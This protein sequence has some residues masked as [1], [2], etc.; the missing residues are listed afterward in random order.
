MCVDVVVVVGGGSFCVG[1]DALQ[2]ILFIHP[3]ISTT[4]S[5]NREYCKQHN[6]MVGWLILWV[7]NDYHDVYNLLLQPGRFVTAVKMDDSQSTH[8]YHQPAARAPT[9]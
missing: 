3:C 2:H 8:T 1:A 9:P 5:N 7:I 4:P 6:C